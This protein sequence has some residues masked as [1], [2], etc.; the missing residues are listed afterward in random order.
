MFI[1]QNKNN[2]EII[3]NLFKFVVFEKGDPVA[4]PV[5]HL[6]FNQ[7]AAGS[8]PA[9]ITIIFLSILYIP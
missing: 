2:F 9:G 7:G 5:E 3:K 8:N 1:H 4:Q 6:T